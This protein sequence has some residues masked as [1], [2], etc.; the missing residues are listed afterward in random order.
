MS[1]RSRFSAALVCCLFAAVAIAGAQPAKPAPAL[2]APAVYGFNVALILGDLNGSSKA[3]NMPEG[4][5]RALADMRDFLPYKSYRLLDTQW[6]LCCGPTKVGT[7]VSGRLRAASQALSVGQ[8]LGPEDQEYP[9]MVS[10]VGVN[11][12]QLSIRFF[13]ADGGG[14]KKL[15]DFDGP[16]PKRTPKPSE[17]STDVK[18]EKELQGALEELTRSPG[19]GAIIDSTFS[20]DIGETVVIGTSSLKGDKALIALLTAAKRPGSQASALGEKR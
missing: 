12:Q 7:G 19:K 15:T 6:I 4:A 18:R 2:G 14:P 1:H 20:M 17:P 3:D 13:M 11:G 10:V 16:T 9:F 5:K 8:G